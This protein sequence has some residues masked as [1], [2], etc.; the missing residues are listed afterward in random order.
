MFEYVQIKI[1]RSRDHMHTCFTAVGTDDIFVNWV[2]SSCPSTPH[3]PNLLHPELNTEQMK[4]SWLRPRASCRCSGFILS[5]GQR[6]IL[7]LI[8]IRPS[9][10]NTMVCRRPQDMSNIRESA[11]VNGSLTSVNLLI[12]INESQHLVETCVTKLSFAGVRQSLAQPGFFL[13]LTSPLASTTVDRQ[14]VQWF[15]VWYVI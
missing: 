10:V 11:L 7:I 6:G 1:L 3:W 8:D 4:K 2:S 14:S 12:T 15:T 9:V 13:W 5:V